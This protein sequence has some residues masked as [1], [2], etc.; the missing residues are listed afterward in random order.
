MIREV[1][2]PLLAATL[3]TEAAARQIEVLSCRVA[4]HTEVPVYIPR[5]LHSKEKAQCKKQGSST[6]IRSGE[7]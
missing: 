1:L 6:N 2:V 5:Q 3:I 7:S 4:V